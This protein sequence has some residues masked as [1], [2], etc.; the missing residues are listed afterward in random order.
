M[1]EKNKAALMQEYVEKVFN[2][3]VEI[4]EI[5]DANDELKTKILRSRISAEGQNLPMAIFVD[6]TIY[7]MIRVQVAEGVV[8]ESNQAKVVEYLNEQNRLYK[9]FKYYVDDQGSIYL[10]A[11]IPG[12]DDETFKP[13]LVHVVLDVIVEHLTENYA[14][15]MKKVWA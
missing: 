3:D 12:L 1:A 15:L 8:K 9:V 2:K 13:E 6:N 10:D 11:C 7:T 5:S 4:F 14:P